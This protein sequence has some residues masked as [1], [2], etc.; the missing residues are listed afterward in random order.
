MLLEPNK[1]Y[2]TYRKCQFLM[3]PSLEVTE[4]VKVYTSLEG[5]KPTSIT[6]MNEDEGIKANKI[7][8]FITVP[9]WIA[10][11]YTSNN[12]E[13]YECGLVT[14]P[15][16]DRSRMN[17]YVEPNDIVIDKF[18]TTLYADDSKTVFDWE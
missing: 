8:S 17:P 10:V 4:G 16:S 14:D 7:N 3:M 5:T 18:G 1:I 6:E 12:D 13:A 9:R 15:L 11:T 2:P